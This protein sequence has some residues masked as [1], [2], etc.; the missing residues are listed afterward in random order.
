MA[1]PDAA[2]AIELLAT[3]S[4]SANF[5]VGCYCEDEARCHRSVLRALLIA[6]GAEVSSQ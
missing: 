4:Q 3:L 2:H 6:A 5:A 1:R